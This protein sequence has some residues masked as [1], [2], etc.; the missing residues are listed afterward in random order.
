MN[1]EV[2]LTIDDCPSKDFRQKVDF[3]KKNKIPAILFCIG[4]LM[5]ER[6]EDIMY[7]IKKGFI[8]G[9]HSYSHPFFNLIS[10]KRAYEEI[11]RTDEIINELHKKARVKRKFKFFRFPYGNKGGRFSL[12]MIFIWS[13]LRDIVNGKLFFGKRKEREIQKYLTGL[14]YRQPKFTGIKYSYFSRLGLDKD[15]DVFWTYDFEEYWRKD[16]NKIISLMGRKNPR[17]GGS[18]ASKESRDIVLIHDHDNTKEAFFRII[19]EMIK[20]QI[21]FKEIR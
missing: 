4:K 7:A 1:K 12:W 14:G 16:V 8:I 2:Y 3:L 13:P 5:K 10:L 20:K 19:N 9:N 17:Q 18:L 11:K 6:P 21:K 15:A